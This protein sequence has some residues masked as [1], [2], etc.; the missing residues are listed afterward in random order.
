MFY[1]KQ[2]AFFFFLFI[3]QFIA[4]KAD[5]TC[6]DKSFDLQIE[7]TIKPQGQNLEIIFYVSLTNTKTLPPDTTLQQYAVGCIEKLFFR[8]DAGAESITAFSTI[9]ST[10]NLKAISVVIPSV[11]PLTQYK[12][13]GGY[14]QSRPIPNQNITTFQD[15]SVSSCFAA[16]S[17]PQ[18][19][20]ASTNTD[21]SVSVSWE[22][23]KQINAPSICYYKVEARTKEGKFKT[24]SDKQ[25][26]LAF[27]ITEPSIAVVKV[28]A[29]N[30]FECYQDKYPFGSSCDPNIGK[31]AIVDVTTVTTTTK[32]S[33]ETTKPSSQTT[34]PSSQTTTTPSGASKGL[35]ASFLL[36]VFLS[37]LSR[38]F[39]L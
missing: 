18:N 34:K 23:P 37:V 14:I 9:D 32:P 5:V 20:A 26:Q 25:L 38:M 8:L 7:N 24:V 22:E 35:T 21:G 4:S 16:P 36:C 11:S 27:K 29:Y 10:T 3:A 28:T 31:E 13:T 30:N 2:F 1:G 17:E 33:S 12:L 6:E 15:V 19:L 39:L